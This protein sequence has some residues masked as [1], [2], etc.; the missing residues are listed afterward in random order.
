M[1]TF[2]GIFHDW[3]G[4]PQ[5]HKCCQAFPK[6]HYILEPSSQDNEPMEF[7][8]PYVNSSQYLRA[9]I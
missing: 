8:S 6:H 9:F 7:I 5:F 3:L 1:E 2:E 4:L